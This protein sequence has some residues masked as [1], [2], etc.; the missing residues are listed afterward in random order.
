MHIS[1]QLCINLGGDLILN[2]LAED[3]KYSFIFNVRCYDVLK[4]VSQG[5]SRA[6]STSF[7]G[8]SLNRIMLVTRN[9]IDK[10]AIQFTL[11]S[12]NLQSRLTTAISIDEAI[13]K[14]RQH[15]METNGSYGFAIVIMDFEQVRLKSE[16]TCIDQFEQGLVD[17]E[18]PY[19]PKI[20][21]LN[22]GIV[23]GQQLRQLKAMNISY[24]LSKPVLRQ[25]FVKMFKEL[26][27]KRNEG[28][29]E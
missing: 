13:D 23:K 18:I 17:Y 25:D 1:K 29:A 12:F 26:K 5:I 16:S 4:K 19:Q 10:L 24:L 9:V 21:L 14:L 22:S 6:S 20:V 3:E 7:D 8:V 11:N 2:Y 15:F 28:V 27:F